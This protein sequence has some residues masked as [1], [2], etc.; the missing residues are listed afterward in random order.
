MIAAIDAKGRRDNGLALGGIRKG[1]RG[2]PV[3]TTDFSVN[4]LRHGCIFAAGT[5]GAWVLL[6]IG[7]LSPLTPSEGNPTLL[8]IFLFVGGPIVLLLVSAVLV[9]RPWSWLAAIAEVVLIL[10]VSVWLLTTIWR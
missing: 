3:V 2:R 8:H 10:A 4:L 6:A 7:F 9:R 5:V 1:S